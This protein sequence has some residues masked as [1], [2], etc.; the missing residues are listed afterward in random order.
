MKEKPVIAYS[1]GAL[2]EIIQEGV[3]GFLVPRRRFDMLAEKVRLLLTDEAMAIKMGHAGRE[4]AQVKFNLSNT[5][6]KYYM[7][8]NKIAG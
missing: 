8:M 4:V 7:L 2:P 6:N 5:V 3:T 1:A